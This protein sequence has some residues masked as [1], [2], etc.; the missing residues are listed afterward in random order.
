MRK[1]DYKNNYID[2]NCKQNKDIDSKIDE[3]MKK[4]RRRIKKKQKHRHKGDMDE[5]T[6]EINNKILLDAERSAIVAKFVSQIDTVVRWD[7]STLSGF[8]CGSVKK[9]V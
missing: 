7:R 8:Y 3:R 5:N 9:K 1:L 4:R 2:G 6:E